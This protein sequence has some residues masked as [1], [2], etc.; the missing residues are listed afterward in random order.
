MVDARVDM[1]NPKVLMITAA[2]IVLGLGTGSIA[3]LAGSGAPGASV[4][5][6]GFTLSGLGLAAISGI[7]LN[8]ILN[9][10]Q[11]RKKS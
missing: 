4:T 9:F 7:V 3:T 2:M 1:G 11:F 5:F 10:S 6:G 8:F